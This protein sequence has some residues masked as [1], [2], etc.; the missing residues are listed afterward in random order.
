MA[1][2]TIKMICFGP[3]AVGPQYE[4]PWEDVWIEYH[5]GKKKVVKEGPCII[6]TYDLQS[7]INIQNKLSDSLPSEWRDKHIDDLLRIKSE[8]SRGNKFALQD[9]EMKS[10]VPNIYVNTEWVTQKTAE[11][12]I[13][14]YLKKKGVLKGKARFNWRKP[15]DLVV[16]PTS[17]GGEPAR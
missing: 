5:L 16:T 3:I 2:K 14:W 13:E 12:A 8:F 1:K 17:I 11:E 9:L 6:G 15:K 7:E 10:D 4:S